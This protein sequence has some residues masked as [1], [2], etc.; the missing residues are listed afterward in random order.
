MT[1]LLM[2]MIHQKKKDPVCEEASKKKHA[3]IDDDGL[4]KKKV[5]H[6]GDVDVDN[7]PSK[8]KYDHDGNADIVNDDGTKKRKK[9]AHRDDDGMQLLVKKKLLDT[10]TKKNKKG[11]DVEHRWNHTPTSDVTLMEV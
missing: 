3:Q 2:L 6:V 10:S 4:S 1:Y 8:R 7:G 9:D 5:D 11:D